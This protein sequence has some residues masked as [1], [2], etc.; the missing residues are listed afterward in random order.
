MKH[1]YLFL[2]I[3]P[4]VAQAQLPQLSE[5]KSEISPQ[6]TPR[7]AYA[8]AAQASRNNVILFEDFQSV[9]VPDLPENWSGGDLVEQQQDNDEGIGLDTYVGAWQTGDAYS[10]NNGGYL[11]VPHINDNL[12][13]FV[14]D[15]GDPCNCDME[16]VGLVTPEMSF[17][18][19]ENLMV[20]FDVYSPGTYGGDNISLQI[21]TDG[22]SF[23]TIYT[24]ESSADWQPVFV[25]L[26]AWENEQSVWLRFAWSDNGFWSSG[27]AIDNVI[28][29]ER[30]DYNG[31][32]LRAHTAEYTGAF[33]DNTIISGE[34]SATPIEQASALTLGATVMN[35]GAFPLENVVLSATVF[36]EG[37]EVGS[38]NGEVISSIFP[39]EQTDLYVYTDYI[40]AQPGE[41]TV[42]YELVADEDED[43]EDNTASRSI[44]YSESTYI[45]DDNETVS[46]RDNSGESFVIG[47][48]FEVPNPGST[49]YSI[50][51][52]IGAGS[53]TDTE[54]MVRLYSADRVF[55]A[56]SAP[57][58]IQSSDRNQLGQ[59]KITDI[60]LTEPYELEAG[61]DYL[62][63]VTYFAEP[64]SEFTVANS[65]IS[66]DQFSV[67]QD[68]IGDWYFVSTTPMVRMNLNSTVNIE[69]EPTAGQIIIAP[70]PVRDTYQL[71]WPNAKPG[72]ATVRISD[73]TGR[74]I[75]ENEV[76]L[77]A[78]GTLLTPVTV[79]HFPSGLYILSVSQG[80]DQ[81]TVLFSKQ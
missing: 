15:D 77:N 7:S 66:Q 34:Y 12:F 65:G 35:K 27:G 9:S 20:T 38:Y 59:H 33:D 41:Y 46:F 13:A 29:A 37:D 22:D 14:N 61:Q 2:L 4:V 68:E 72:Q 40:P 8:M 69:E 70:N 57:Y 71:H 24:A 64:T 5:S 53:N 52:G 80:T 45:M 16:D 36:Y 58:Q 25:D 55:L 11:P 79:S 43:L 76:Q 51:V 56:G 81:E 73:I 75:A 60:P 21:S 47:N 6:P 19:M 42:S 78:D 30:L 10:A 3:V 18:G 1:L 31:S 28:V 63:V 26:S 54:I 62:A 50:G 39:M 49:C 32:I 17:E 67:F 48:M 74:V 23:T 44:H